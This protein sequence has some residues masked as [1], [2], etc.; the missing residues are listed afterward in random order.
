ML[1]AVTVGPQSRL[2]GVLRR[3]VAL[4]GAAFIPKAEGWA[5]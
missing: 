3:F 4:R 2:I 1:R 5:A